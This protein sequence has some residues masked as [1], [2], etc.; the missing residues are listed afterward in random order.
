MEKQIIFPIIISFIISL[1]S[2]PFVI[3]G[4]RALKASQ[5][6]RKEGVA[7]H[8]KKAGTPTMGGIMI[9]LGILI[10]SLFFINQKTIPVLF[11]T[12][13]FGCIGFLDD[14]LKVFLRRS[15]GLLPKQ[16][17]L[18]QILV[19]AVFIFLLKRA[20]IGLELL[21]PFSGGKYLSIG[22]LAYP[23]LLI[24]VLATVN[25]VNFTDGLDGLASSVTVVVSLFF[26]ISATVLGSGTEPMS[27][28]VIGAL[29]GFLVYNAYPAK[30]FMGDTGSLAL[31]GFVAG[32]A[33]V[34]KMPLFILIVGLIYAIELLSVV[35]QVSYFKAT[36][37]KR[38]FKMTPIHHHFEL[39]HW[40]E[41]KI[42]TVFTI[43]TALM[44]LVAF[45]HFN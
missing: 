38:I 20:G 25:G 18:L 43:I 23:L 21:L 4:M 14:F 40:S 30:I 15:D 31:G 24:A 2:G 45:L 28:A 33:Y 3:N 35:I 42:V 22:I 41:T 7:S 44:S 32:I 26:L 11:L 8:L 36:H 13:G 17:L 29:M 16:K 27:G 34:Q 10:T 37:G 12:I 5:T 19:T 39:S 1:I 6:E 9:L